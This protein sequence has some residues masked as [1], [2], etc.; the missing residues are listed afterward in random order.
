MTERARLSGVSTALP[1][2]SERPSACPRPNFRPH[3]GQH[4]SGHSRR[5]SCRTRRS[6]MQPKTR[7]RAVAYPASARVELLR[8][9]APGQCRESSTRYVQIVVAFTFGF[10]G[11]HGIGTDTDAG[12]I[13]LMGARLYDPMTGRFLQ[14]DPV[15]GGSCNAYD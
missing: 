12:G 7:V 10:E 13:V 5:S 1:E 3:R 15:F 9:V 6:S 11:K 8:F 14:V 2:S 4:L